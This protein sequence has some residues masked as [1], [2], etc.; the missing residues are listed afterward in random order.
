MWVVY[1][2]YM[3]EPPTMFKCFTTEK[4]AEE[5][6]SSQPWGKPWFIVE[7]SFEGV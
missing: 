2:S 5:F 6:V 4:S 1:Y 7:A 3:E